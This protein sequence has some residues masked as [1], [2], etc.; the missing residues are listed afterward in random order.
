MPGTTKESLLR[1]KHSHA[2]PNDLRL[3]LDATLRPC[4][5]LEP[6]ADRAQLHTRDACACAQQHQ[7]RIGRHTSNQPTYQLFGGG[8]TVRAPFLTD[9]QLML[10]LFAHAEHRT[11]R[12]ST[13]SR[14][15]LKCKGSKI[16]PLQRTNTS[17][18]L[19]TNSGFW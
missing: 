2:L 5:T 15:E 19:G 8:L 16:L 6:V 14:A 7:H 10:M 4:Q 9:C 3:T 12:H 11:A 13:I 1:L 17:V 18:E